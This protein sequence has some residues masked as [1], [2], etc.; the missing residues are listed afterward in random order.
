[1]PSIR[2]QIVSI[3]ALRATRFWEMLNAFNS[4]YSVNYA[5]SLKSSSFAPPLAALGMR[6]QQLGFRV[7]F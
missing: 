4:V 3:G 5:G 2:R 7:E 1:M 6:R